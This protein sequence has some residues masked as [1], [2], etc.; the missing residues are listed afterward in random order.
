MYWHVQYENK[1]IFSS[2]QKPKIINFPQAVLEIGVPLTSYLV[3]FSLNISLVA[4][5]LTVFQVG[6]QFPHRQGLMYL[7]QIL[8][9]YYL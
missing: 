3:K 1:G 4:K 2:P 9:K 8:F 7:I 5:L 6:H